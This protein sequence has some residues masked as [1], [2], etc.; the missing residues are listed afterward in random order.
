M[1]WANAQLLDDLRLFGEEEVTGLAVVLN[2]TRLFKPA[3]LA[4]ADKS[5]ILLGD[6]LTGYF[7]YHEFVGSKENTI[8]WLRTT[9]KPLLR[10]LTENYNDITTPNQVTEAHL[11]EYLAV[12][13]TTNQT[14]SLNNK[15]RA[16]KAFFNH[17][18]K[19][20][21]VEKNP[22]EGLKQFKA[23]EKA[24]PCFSKEQLKDLLA[25]PD[26]KTFTGLRDR[27]AM[28]V[29]MDIALRVGE[30]LNIM[31]EDLLFDDSLPAAIRVRDPKNHRERIANLPPVPAKALHKWLE[32]LKANV[33]SPQW[34][35]PNI[36]GDQLSI[37]TL[38][39]NITKYG[40]KAGITGRCSPHMFRHSFAKH[41]I[42]AGGD[43]RS[44]QEILGHSTITM[45]LRY[46]KLFNP[47]I[48]K[49][50]L[51]FCPSN[52]VLS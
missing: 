26:V 4:S 27:T 9:L 41:Y 28:L 19:E 37:R 8:K 23:T 42:I 12:L 24:V 50:H 1:P 21:I 52:T 15:I 43:L 31:V 32:Y 33:V 39:E 51:M 6:A 44:L 25:Q 47:D 7:E 13:R 35:F 49:K 2:R 3:R 34:L 18:Y 29:M 16:F 30:L 5:S 22:T 48:R 10:F 40:R 45:T 17:L 38:Q 20:G 11:K 46:G 14:V 36:Y